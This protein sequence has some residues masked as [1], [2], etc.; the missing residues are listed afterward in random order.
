[1]TTIARIFLSLSLSLTILL[2]MYEGDSEHQDIG[3]DLVSVAPGE[4]VCWDAEARWTPPPAAAAA[5][6]GVDADVL[7]THR[8]LVGI[9][10]L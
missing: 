4:V 2:V 3:L 5:V 6:H 1:M 9:G 10:G 7:S 8:H